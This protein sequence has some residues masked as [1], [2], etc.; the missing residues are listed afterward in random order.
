MIKLFLRDGPYLVDAVEDGLQAVTKFTN[1]TY[2]LVFM[3]IQMP[4]MDGYQATREIREWERTTQRVPTP[5]IALTANA[6]QEEVEKSLE[7]GCTAHMT[8]PIRK[9]TLL[10]AITRFAQSKQGEEV[11]S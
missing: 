9:K 8:K 2:D 5:I 4:V 6:F 11:R 7:V 1:A 3:D 10:A